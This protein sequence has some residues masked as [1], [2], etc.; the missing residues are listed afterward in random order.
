MKY[1]FISLLWLY[2]SAVSA[3]ELSRHVA[4]QVMQAQKHAEQQQLD[5]AIQTLRAV[6]AEQPQDKAYVALLLANYYWQNGQSQSAIEQARYAVT[7]NQLKEAMGWR[8]KRMLA[9]LLANDHQYQEAVTYYRQ[10]VEHA[11]VKKDVPQLWLRI[12]Q[13]HYQLAQWQQTLDAI[14]QYERFQLPDAVM[15]LSIQ[16]GAQIQLTR[17]QA[18]IPTIKRLLALEPDQRNWWLQLVNMEIKT[19]QYRAALASL[20]LARLKG[21]ELSDQNLK[22][23]ANLYAQNGIPERAARVMASL[24][25]QSPSV[26]T[27]DDITQMAY[28][29]QQAKEWDQAIENWRIAAQQDKKY[30]RD[31]ARLQLQQGDYQ[32]ALETL[33]LLQGHDKAADI[34]LLRTQ[35]LY[36]LNQLDQALHQAKK[37]DSLEPSREAKS[38]IKYLTQLHQYRQNRE[39]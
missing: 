1:I 37:A 27:L 17:Y 19:K 9:D 38:W 32:E 10:L 3:V 36:K 31:V 26:L 6:T 7:S 2:A 23:L 11:P 21:V 14:A 34:A 25:A 12:G 39:S 30:Y 15:P 33:A 13:I 8:A 16:L 24:A 29:W 35:A 22:L 20:E 18:A 5:K 28:Y 4:A